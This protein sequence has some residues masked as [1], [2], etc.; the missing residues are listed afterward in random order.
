[1]NITWAMTRY[2]LH[3]CLT[4][5]WKKII[6]IKDRLIKKIKQIS[7]LSMINIISIRTF[8][9]T[10]IEATIMDENKNHPNPETWI[11]SILNLVSQKAYYIWQRQVG[12][13]RMKGRGLG[14]ATWKLNI[15]GIHPYS[16]KIS[17]KKWLKVGKDQV[18]R[19][20]IS[21]LAWW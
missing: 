9:L 18:Y 15:I 14:E 16:K 6:K 13:P 17:I 10:T 5:F 12:S 8:F 2:I 19:E 3:C 1:M 21:V 7:I 4:K 20:T 11:S